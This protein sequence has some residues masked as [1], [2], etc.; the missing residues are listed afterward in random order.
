MTP[1][2]AAYKTNMRGRDDRW[3]DNLPY[4]EPEYDIAQREVK[5]HRSWGFVILRGDNYKS[6]EKWDRY[7]ARFKASIRAQLEDPDATRL[8]DY[9]DWI[10][11]EDESTM[12]DLDIVDRIE[13]AVSIFEKWIEKNPFAELHRE[14]IFILVDDEMLDTLDEEASLTNIHVE[15]NLFWAVHAPKVRHAMQEKK[16][17]DERGPIADPSERRLQ[18]RVWKDHVNTMRREMAMSDFL[19]SYYYLKDNGWYR[20]QADRYGVWHC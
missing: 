18:K 13:D 16:K 7:I 14:Q 10:I 11:L 12:H 20:F 1:L 9:L 6:Q 5:Y 3:M 17:M 19:V 4:N 8:A 2:H 15:T